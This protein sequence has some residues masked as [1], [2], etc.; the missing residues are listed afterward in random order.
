MDMEATGRGRRRGIRPEWRPCRKTADPFPLFSTLRPSKRPPARPAAPPPHARLMLHSPIHRSH[1][2]AG[3]KVEW[4]GSLWPA[5]LE[6]QS[7]MHTKGAE[8]MEVTHFSSSTSC[9]WSLLMNLTRLMRTV[10]LALCL[11]LPRRTRAEI[12]S[13]NNVIHI[14]TQPHDVLVC[15]V[16]NF[17]RPHLEFYRLNCFKI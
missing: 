15:C 11:Q 13:K 8:W 3:L 12:T 14:R 16:L 10:R 7:Q 4:I 6:K 5:S 9:L 1:H 2:T 17:F